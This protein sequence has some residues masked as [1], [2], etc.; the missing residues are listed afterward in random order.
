MSYT[1]TGQLCRKAGETMATVY[2]RRE[3]RPIPDGATIGTY[4][5]K[6][7]ATWTDAKGKAQRAPLNAA[8]DRIIQCGRMLHGPI[9]RRDRQATQGPHGMPRQGRS[10]AVREPSGKPSTETADGRNRREGRTLREGSPAAPVGT[11]CGLQ[12]V[13]GGQGQHRTTRCPDNP[14]DTGNHRPDSTRNISR[15]WTGQQ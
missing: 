15:T 5:G 9:L 7:Y 2:K 13:S 1:V 12:A 10:F 8:G 6:P 14:T 3:L 4:R 11:R